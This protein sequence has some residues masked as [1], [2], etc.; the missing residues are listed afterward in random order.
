VDVE[1]RSDAHRG[2]DQGVLVRP[3]SIASASAISSG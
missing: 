1:A 3:A 2:D